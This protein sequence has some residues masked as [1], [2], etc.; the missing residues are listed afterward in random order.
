MIPASFWVNTQRVLVQPYRHFGTICRSR[1]VGRVLRQCFAQLHR[2]RSIGMHFE[3]SLC[4]SYFTLSTKYEL[5]DIVCHW[6]HVTSSA[7]VGVSCSL[8]LSKWN[9]VHRP[10]GPSEQ[11]R[12]ISETRGDSQGTR[13]PLCKAALRR[14]ACSVSWKLGFLFFREIR[15]V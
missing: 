10:F 7:Y 2:R 3:L 6:N 9:R 14:V 5:S 4:M 13:Q 1:N 8:C 12:Q 15:R 11:R